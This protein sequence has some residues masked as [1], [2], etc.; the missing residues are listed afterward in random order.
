MVISVNKQEIKKTIFPGGEVHVRLPSKLRGCCRCEIETSLH[1]SDDLMALLLVVDAIKQAHS[2]VLIYLHISYF[3]YARQDRVCN[4]GEALGVR[5]V[6]DMINSLNCTSVTIDD[7]HSDVVVSLI[8]NGKAVQAYHCMSEIKELVNLMQMDGLFLLSPDA[9]AEKRT[10]KIAQHFGVED[11]IYARKIRDTKTG[12]I[13]ATDVMCHVGGRDILITDD[14]CDGGRTFT[15]LGK[16]LKMRGAGDVYLYVTHGI[17]SKGLDELRK[18]FTKIY[19]YNV[20]DK[21]LIDGEFLVSVN[22]EG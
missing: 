22:N 2:L 6:A 12:E 5:V 18:Y 15:E 20:F 13:I 9:G 3:P 14:I 16:V 17:F 10:L 8:R 1:N 7:P 21:S 19:C 4:A 11:I